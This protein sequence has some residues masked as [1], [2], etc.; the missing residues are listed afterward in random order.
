MVSRLM[1][2]SLIV[3][4][5]HF[6]LNVYVTEEGL[7]NRKLGYQRAGPFEIIEAVGSQAYKLKLPPH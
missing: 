1:Q 3:A 2:L 6:T 5:C 7:K 4:S